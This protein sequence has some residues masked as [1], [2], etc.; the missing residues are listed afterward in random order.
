MSRVQADK[1]YT[2]FQAGFITEATGLTFPENSC[3]DIDNCDIELKGT[4]RRRLGLNVERGGGP[5][6]RN[7]FADQTFEGASGPY[8]NATAEVVV[9]QNELAVT[10]HLWP[11]PSSRD[12]MNLVV[13]QVG[14][15]ITV[16]DWDSENISD[17]GNL[18]DRITGTVSFR[19]DDADTGFM[20]NVSA[21]EA[22]RI[23][24]NTSVGFGRIWFTSKAVIPFYMELYRSEGVTRLR[25]LPVGYDEDTAPNGTIQIRDFNGVNDGLQVDENPVTLSDLH[26]YNLR[27]QGW[28]VQKI[29]DFFN[30]ND[31]GVYPSNAQQWVLGKGPD[32]IFDY[33][34]LIRQDFGTSPAPKGRFKLHALIGDKSQAAA[35]D[36]DFN[37]ELYNFCHPSPGF[38]GDLICAVK[39]G[40]DLVPPADELEIPRRYGERSQTS[41]AC[42]AFFGGR[43][44][45]AGDE[46]QKRPNGVYYSKTMTRVEDAGQMC[47]DNDPTSEHFSDL[48][49]TDGGTIYVTE[50]DRILR[51]MPFASGL[52]VFAGNGV[53]FIYGGEGGFTA[54]NYAVD[55]ISNVGLSGTDTLVRTADACVYFTADSIYAITL[56]PQGAVPVATDVAETKILSFYSRIDASARERAQGCYDPIS[57]KVFW[58]YLQQD[59]YDYPAYGTAYNR[60]L[61]LDTRTGAYTKYSFVTDPDTNFMLGWSFPKRRLARPHV[62]GNVLIGEDTVV[63]GSDNVVVLDPDSSTDDFLTS[64]KTIIWQGSGDRLRL[65]EFYDTSFMDFANIETQDYT[66][67]VVTGDETLGDLTRNKQASYVWS[68]FRR[69]EQGFR[70]NEDSD[71]ILIRPSACTLVARWDWHNTSAGGRWSEPQ[72]A[73]RYRRGFSGDSVDN[74]EEI[75]YTKLKIRGKGHALSLK[76]ESVSGK[77]FQLLGLAIPFTATG[78]PS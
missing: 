64:I 74:G 28:S 18:S 11:Q 50:A 10:C 56:P 6:A 55:K 59:E 13:F 14:N 52:L 77:D 29:A 35:S 63:V 54:T 23:P 19:I 24:L 33:D 42:T 36:S 75:L 26:E 65:C 8:S 53:W 48:L 76:Y 40:F 1:A 4:A 49:A 15:V 45:L 41:Y 47:S 39:G 20:Y 34:L 16:R 9:P 5:L 71:L 51:L 7:R 21:D 73:Y 2:N 27:N 66:S 44:W 25:I 57:K 78:A 31:S 46:N 68:Y 30:D 3:R 43:L 67:Y 70:Q 72:Q 58:S 69:T 32:D 22:A 61:I 12:D 37:W 17:T 62:V 60:M 38:P